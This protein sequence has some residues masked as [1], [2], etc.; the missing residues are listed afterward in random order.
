MQAFAAGYALTFL[1]ILKLQLDSWIVAPNPIQ[2]SK[3]LLGFASTVILGIG[4][5]RDP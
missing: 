2:S 1:T 4:P 3:L 5:C